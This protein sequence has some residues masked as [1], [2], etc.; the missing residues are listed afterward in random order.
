[1]TFNFERIM[2]EWLTAVT[3]SYLIIYGRFMLFLLCVRIFISMCV[4]FI[5]IV[6]IHIS[7][8]D[9]ADEI[10][11]LLGSGFW[12]FVGIVRVSQI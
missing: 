3:V 12:T 8:E 2:F 1:M 11:F 7:T 10:W 9:N 4:A 6:G 5:L